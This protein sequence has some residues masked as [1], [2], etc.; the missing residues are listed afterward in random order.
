M[1]EKKNLGAHFPWSTFHWCPDQ[2]LTALFVPELMEGSVL[3]RRFIPLCS[4]GKSL[5]ELPILI[6]EVNTESTLLDMCERA[7]V[8]LNCVGPVRLFVLSDRNQNSSEVCGPHRQPTRCQHSPVSENCGTRVLDIGT[9]PRLEFRAVFVA[10]CSDVVGVVAVRFPR[11]PGGPRLH[12]EGRFASRHLR[13]AAGQCAFLFIITKVQHGLNIY[14]PQALKLGSR[15]IS[16]WLL[17]VDSCFTH[18]GW[19][20]HNIRWVVLKAEFILN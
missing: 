5:E 7:R 8:V 16:V 12:R 2:P 1:S 3:V 11:Q 4:A 13:G 18:R 15:H 6:A 9:C 14:Q 19:K 20:Q 17:S 10:P